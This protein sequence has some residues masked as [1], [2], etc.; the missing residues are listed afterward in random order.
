MRI[1]VD[2]RQA[3]RPDPRGIGKVLRRLLPAVAQARPQW[4]IAAVHRCTTGVNPYA[5]IPS[6]IPLYR[7]MP[8][9]RFDFWERYRFPWTASRFHADLMHSPANSGPDWSPVPLL[10]HIHDLIPLDEEPNT[11][12]TRRWLAGIQRG[13]R[14][15]RAIATGSEY[16]RHDIATRLGVPRE[17]IHI[18]PYGVS[19]GYRPIQESFDRQALLSSYGIEPGEP[20]LFAFAA[21]DPRKNISLL[22]EAHAAVPHA[23]RLVL[24]GLS[25]VAAEPF[26]WQAKKLGTHDRVLFCG[27]V[28]EPDIPGLLS[29]A[30]AVVFPSRNEGFGLPVLEAFACG[31]T[32][33]AGNRTSVPEVAHE[34]ARLFDPYSVDEL[35][36]ALVE[37]LASPTRRAWYC[38]RL[39]RYC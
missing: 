20:Y 32:V 25:E 9:D 6:I 13:L 23:P 31:A 24:V 4:Q 30:L 26:A 34:A 12:A 15:A 1:C 2:A 7:E 3:Y 27:Y 21:A 28:A 8:G 18:V 35:R 22:L 14:A 36:Q 16:S 10:M 38:Q 37:I 29:A 39:L 11:A 33:I 19:E 5:G 17:R